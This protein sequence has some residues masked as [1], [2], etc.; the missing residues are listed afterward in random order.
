MCFPPGAAT[1]HSGHDHVQREHAG[2]D[3]G[4]CDGGAQHSESSMEI[5]PAHPYE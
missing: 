5:A 1:S 4:N 3:D 2:H